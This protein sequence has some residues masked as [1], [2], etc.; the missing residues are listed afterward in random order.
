MRYLKAV[1]AICALGCG[2]ATNPNASIHYYFATTDVKVRVL[3]T[4]TCNEQDHLIVSNAATVT[5]EHHAD[6]KHQQKFNIAKLDS[7][8]SN[9]DIAFDFYDDGRLKSINTTNTGQG[10]AIVRS[11]VALAAGILLL[12]QQTFPEKCDFINGYTMKDGKKVREKSLTLAFEGLVTPKD[13][14]TGVPTLIEIVPE[15]APQFNKLHDVL[16]DV[17]AIIQSIGKPLP[18]ISLNDSN[19]AKESHDGDLHLDIRPPSSVSIKIMAGPDK[20][21]DGD[22]EVGQ[23]GE[24]FAVPIPKAAIF[25]QQGFILALTEAGSI[26]KIGYGK[27]TGVAQVLT[28]GSVISE[29][30]REKTTAEKAAEVKAEADL[31]AQQQRLVRCQAD[32]KTCN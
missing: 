11:V 9:T 8:F 30:F 27:E 7:V 16:G 1:L 31:I 18:P 23:F 3:R 25:G 19:S 29:K 10:E 21:W 22:V 24:V 4:V 32:P 15:N 17:S 13:K 6:T 14:K 2:C 28:S 12:D 26:S 20:V 5:P